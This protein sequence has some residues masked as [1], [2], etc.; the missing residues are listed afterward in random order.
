MYVCLIA[1]LRLLWN[2]IVPCYLARMRIRYSD[3]ST[4]T[5]TANATTLIVNTPTAIASVTTKATVI[6][7]LPPLL[8]LKS[9]LLLWLWKWITAMA[10]ISYHQLICCFHILVLGVQLMQCFPS[11]FQGTPAHSRLAAWLTNRFHQTVKQVHDG[12]IHRR[13][14]QFACDGF[15]VF[16]LLINTNSQSDTPRNAGFFL[17]RFNNVQKYW[18]PYMS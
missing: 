3:T 15:F 2:V 10:I 13:P 5:A 11:S 7:K 17:L 16:L 4:A 12:G 14:L 8:L 6:V 9:T 1:F 18:L